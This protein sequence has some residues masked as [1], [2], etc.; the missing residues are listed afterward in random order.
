MLQKE[1]IAK[2]SQKKSQKLA[3]SVPRGT[4]DVL[5]QEYRYW[6][7]VLNTIKKLAISFNFEYIQTPII[8]YAKLFEKGTGAATDIV[9]KEMFSFTTKGGDKL[10]L[11]PEGTPSL[12]RAYL[13]N[14]MVNWAHPIKLCS[15]G[16][17]YRYE[18]PQSGR[19]REFYQYN[20]D[21]FGSDDPIIDV[22]LIYLAWKTF[23]KLGIKNVS[24]QVNSIGC[25]KCRK[26]YKGVLLSFLKSKKGDLCKDC[27]E[28]ILLNPLRV[29][30]CKNAQCQKTLAEAPQIVDYL[31]KECHDHLTLLLEYLDGMEIPYFLNSRLVRGI[32]YYARTVFEIWSE[33]E[34]FK[35]SRTAFCAGGRYDGLVELLGGKKVS[36]VGFAFGVDRIVNLLEYYQIPAIK[37]PSPKVFVVALGVS[38]KKRGLKILSELIDAGIPA[39]E[40]FSKDSLK[41]QLKV[42]DKETVALS[43]II[44]QKEALDETVIIR[45]MASGA[46]EIVGLNKIIS[47][48][49]RMLKNI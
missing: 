49:K 32:D 36:A 37:K 12:A 23:V 15:Y 13:E 35:E 9:Q 2:E 44:G 40:A 39:D 47:E 21:V 34:E 42:A 27:A 6:E 25:E 17:M 43:L 5:P 18:R 28:R 31:C 41:S 45:D 26:D 38:G 22:E 33:E 48:V 10:S 3:M 14:G 16:P 4:K 46:Q 19:K 11:R 1:Q 7:M 20:F 24:V 8:E 30:D 29:L